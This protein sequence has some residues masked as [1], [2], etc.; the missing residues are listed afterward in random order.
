MQIRVRVCSVTFTSVTPV[1][2]KG[3]LATITSEEQAADFQQANV[4]GG[5]NQPPIRRRSSSIGLSP[6]QEAPPAMRILGAINDFGLGS[7]AWW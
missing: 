6:D 1:A 4:D 5:G 7:V 3:L 2:G